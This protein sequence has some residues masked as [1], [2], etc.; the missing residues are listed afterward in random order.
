MSQLWSELLRITLCPDQIVLERGKLIVSLKGVE[1]RYFVPEIIPVDPRHE[2]TLWAAPLAVLSIA[3]DGLP[4]RR[5][6]A[7][8]ILSNHFAHYPM[9]PTD[10]ASGAHDQTQPV[11]DPGLQ[12]A[13]AV[14]LDQH[15]CRLA[16]LEPRIIAI[17]TSQLDELHG[18]SGWLVLVEEGLACLGLIQDWE[19][20]WLRNL[21]MWPASSVALLA[22]LDREARHA[23]LRRLPRTLLLWQRDETDEVILPFNSDWNILRVGACPTAPIPLISAYSEKFMDRA[24]VG[25]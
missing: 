11:I 15:Q 22:V 6:E 1:P 18:E 19:F 13:L 17:G 14:L 9:A 21:C 10:V 7:C 16:S 25:I 4:E 20:M 3:L 8:V 5:Y 2:P 12:T 24:R 23:G